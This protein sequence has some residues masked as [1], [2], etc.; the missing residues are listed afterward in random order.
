MNDGRLTTLERG[1]LIPDL[2]AEILA[3]KRHGLSRRA[4]EFGE[5]SP[6]GYGHQEG[7]PRRTTSRAASG[8]QR[9]S[10]GVPHG[11][12]LEGPACPLSAIPDVPSLFQSVEQGRCLEQGAIPACPRRTRQREDQY[13]RM[14]SGWHLRKCQKRGCDI[15]PTKRGKGTKIMAL[16]DAHGFALSIRTFSARPNEVTLAERTVRSSPIKPE[17][18]IADRVY[19]S[20][21]L[22]ASMA[23]RGRIAATG[24]G[25]PP[26][27]AGPCADT[28]AEGRSNACS[29]GS[30]T[31]VE[32]WSAM[33]TMSRTIWA[34]FNSHAS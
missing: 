22:R 23:K 13:H 28:V 8:A 30:S 6:G 16:T 24:P 15:G 11:S 12:T 2:G 29:L 9:Y 21:K 7:P 31:G 14:L 34:L 10:L 19:E 26:R 1:D 20:D 33:S 17:R 25:R 4:M 32:R 18:V 27:M 3:R 5:G